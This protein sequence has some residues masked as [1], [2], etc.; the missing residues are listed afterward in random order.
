VLG[1]AASQ[2][3]KRDDPLDPQNR[4]ISIIVMNR[5][6]EGRLLNPTQADEPV[7]VQDLGQVVPRR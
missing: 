4:R 5:E 6:A 1:L 3:F 2:P 7:S